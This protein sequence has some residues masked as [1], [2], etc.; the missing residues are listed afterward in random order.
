LG[1]AG[2]DDFLRADGDDPLA[3][4]GLAAVFLG[5]LTGADASKRPARTPTSAARV[6]VA[7]RTT[8]VTET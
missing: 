8:T 6:A 7:G 4:P 5:V 3:P 2:L 1:E